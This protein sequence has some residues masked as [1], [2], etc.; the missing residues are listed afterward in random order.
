[1]N[2]QSDCLICDKHNGIDHEPPGGYIYMGEYFAVCHAPVS[3]GP[4]G[5]LLIE[6]RRHLLDYTSMSSE[7]LAAYGPLLRRV[8]NALRELTDAERIYQV[9]M[10]DGVP[11]FHCWLVP[12]RPNDTIKGVKFLAMDLSCRPKDAKAITEKLRAVL[13]SPNT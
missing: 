4:L 3:T 1:M 13:N 9:A 2:G 10:I 7:A 11:H 5:T 8:Y 6:S 12:R